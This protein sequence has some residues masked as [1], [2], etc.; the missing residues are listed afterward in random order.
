MVP[1]EILVRFEF[2]LIRRP[3]YRGMAGAS[4]GWGADAAKDS[5][6][7]NRVTRAVTW[8]CGRDGA[9]GGKLSATLSRWNLRSL[10]KLANGFLLGG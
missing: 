8:E 1:V 7:G 3:L 10:Q 6:V 5:W 9:G 4:R 2:R